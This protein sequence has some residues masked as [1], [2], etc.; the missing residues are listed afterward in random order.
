[1]IL[2]ALTNYYNRLSCEE[3][4]GIAPLG[5]SPQKISFTL[6]LDQEG[7]LI[8]VQDVRDMSGKKPLPVEYIVPEPTIRTLAI[9]PNFMWDNSGYVLGLDSKGKPE[10]STKAFKAFK[11]L[12]HQIGDSIDD[13]G[14]KSVLI[15]LDKWIPGNVPPGVDAEE[16]NGA[17][18][19]FRIKSERNFI[20]DR[21]KIVDAWIDYKNT[22]EQGKM[23]ICLISGKETPIA[24]LHPKI[25]GVRDAQSMGASIVSFNLNSFC[26]FG[27]EQNYNAPIGTMAAFS[28]TTALNHL[29]R[30]DSRQKVQI[31]DATTIF[32]TERTSPV[33][34]FMGT[35]LDPRNVDSADAK[36][37]EDYL[38][39]I[40]KGI[41]PNSIEDENLCIF[42]LGL[43]PNASRLSVRFWYTEPIATMNRNI[44]R[45]Y[46]DL[47]IVREFDSQAEFPSIWQLQIETAPLRK[48][49][50]IN[51]L[52]SGALIRSI[53][54]GIQYPN[55][56]LASLIGRIRADRDINYYRAGMIKAILR[57]NFGKKEVS[58][59][60]NSGAKNPAYLLGRLFSVL[61]KTQEEAIPGANATIKDRFFGSASAT[62]SVVFPQLIRL[63]QHHL[64]KLDGGAKIYK[65][66]LIQEILSGFNAEL[67]FPAHL[68]LED[69]GMFTLGYY[70]QR[71]DFFTK[72]ADREQSVEND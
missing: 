60:L 67:G 37:V 43:S 47:E 59:S 65:E 24:N 1:M 8:Q 62:P 49:E 17:N 39:A 44:G 45:H 61:E 30:F 21:K 13:M 29:L 55:Y 69:Q 14:M 41:K 36:K 12:H 31:G 72:K 38:M 54:S 68:S 28:Y 66:Q 42:I 48:S 18:I 56:L 51:P 11:E 5:F 57:R 64:A 25:K 35:I 15:F 9:S 10:R 53:L 27:K 7:N 20:H 22:Q 58:M 19:V 71:K 2:Q 32:W 50:N 6:V 3:D 16:L 33:E 23:G 34:S 70:H 46:A 52:L 40:R 4:S 63:S 26:S